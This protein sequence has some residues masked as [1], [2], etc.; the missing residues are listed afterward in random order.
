MDT[1]RS[2]KKTAVLISGQLRT[3]EKCLPSIHWYVLRKLP[4]PVIFISCAEDKESPLASLVGELG[5]STFIESVE[6]P[7]IPVPK[8]KCLYPPMELSVPIDSVLKQF[9]HLRR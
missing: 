7:H 2:H 8:I 6:Q 4:N 1:N 9:W 5:Y 3:W